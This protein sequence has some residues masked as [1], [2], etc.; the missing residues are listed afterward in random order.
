MYDRQRPDLVIHLAAVVGG[1]G[2]NQDEPGKFFFDNAIMG[3]Q[4]IYEANLYNIEKLVAVGTICCYPKYAP[5]PFKEENLWDGI[6]KR[7][8]PLMG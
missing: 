4:L 6:Q 5:I 7:L 2:A 3:L 8:M 1:I